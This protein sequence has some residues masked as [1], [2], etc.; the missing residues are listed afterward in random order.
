MTQV[1]RKF[2]IR[3]SNFSVRAVEEDQTFLVSTMW[4]VRR[5]ESETSKR[6]RAEETL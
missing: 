5:S 6:E 1:A 3:A 2:D 4:Q